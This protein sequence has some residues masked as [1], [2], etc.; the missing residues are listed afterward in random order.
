MIVFLIVIGA[1][2]A[3]FTIDANSKQADR[4][5]WKINFIIIMVQDLFLNPFLLLTFQILLYKLATSTTLARMMPRLMK[6]INNKLVNKKLSFLTAPV[7]APPKT[8]RRLTGKSSGR[9]F[10]QPA[11]SENSISYLNPPNQSPSSETWA[12]NSP[13]MKPSLSNNESRIYFVQNY[14]DSPTD[15][16]GFSK[17]IL[18]YQGIRSRAESNFSLSTLMRAKS[19]P[20]VK[21]KK[22]NLDLLN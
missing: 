13:E 6:F 3:I 22:K 8:S 17:P 4:D 15:R 10:D 20:M 12:T 5:V 18:S 1:I 11:D 14:L 21:R 2:L 9:L 16:A 19:K 7:A